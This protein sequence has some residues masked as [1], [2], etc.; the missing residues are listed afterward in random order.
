[1]IAI[2][3]APVSYGVFELTIGEPGL[4]GPEELVSAVADAGYH[5]IDLGPLGFLGQG[6]ELRERL[7]RHGLA[8]AGGYIQLRF[9]DPAGLEEDLR[10]L[11]LTL[12]SFEV[13]RDLFPELPPK[14]TLAD[15]GS[16]ARAANPGRGRDL[17]EIGLD[18]T[19]WRRLAEGVQRAADRC[20]ERGFEPTFHHHA[21]TYVEAPHEIE[22]LLELTDVGL[23]LDSGH[24]LLGGGDPVRALEDWGSRVNH[25]QLKDARRE[26]LHRIIREGAGMRAVWERGAFCAFGTGDLDID[27]FLDGV[28]RLGYR[29]WIVV[30]EDRI[31]GAP[32]AFHEAVEAQRRN[33]RY[34]ADRGW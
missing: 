1:M 12:D 33:R 34:L 20:R 15:A 28:R 10:T 6:A 31:L 2:A 14:P 23:C 5:G 18:D 22:R 13:V 16:P 24:L 17:P 26:V 29:G 8:L 32:A 30:E 21:C 9:L 11:D 19:A 25:L 7:L 27:A 3:N 4:P